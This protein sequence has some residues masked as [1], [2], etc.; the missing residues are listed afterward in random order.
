MAQKVARPFA[1]TFLGACRDSEKAWAVARLGE[2]LLPAHK[3]E[4][5]ELLE[6]GSAKDIAELLQRMGANPY[7]HL[8]YHRGVDDDRSMKLSVL[9]MQAFLEGYVQ[10]RADASIDLERVRDDIANWVQDARC[11]PGQFVDLQRITSLVTAPEQRSYLMAAFAAPIQMSIMALA[12][13]VTS[14]ASEMHP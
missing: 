10:S 12:T 13:P 3:A 5:V 9:A 1:D 8:A 14:P 11:P 7:A 4:L 6:T 2:K